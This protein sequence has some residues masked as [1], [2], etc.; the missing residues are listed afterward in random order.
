MVQIHDRPRR[1]SSAVPSRRS[2]ERNVLKPES[3]NGFDPFDA[4]NTESVNSLMD[5]KKDVGDWPTGGDSDHQTFDPFGV[6]ATEMLEKTIQK[7]SERGA[8]KIRRAPGRSNSVGTLSLSMADFVGVEKEKEK[9]KQKADD[10]MEFEAIDWNTTAEAAP[11]KSSKGRSRRHSM[12]SR[13]GKG[14]KSDTDNESVENP[15]EKSS[16]S[17]EKP[18]SSSSSSSKDKDKYKDASE[19]DKKK[20]KKVRSAK[21]RR[22]SLDSALSNT[23]SADDTEEDGFGPVKTYGFEQP[24][25]IAPSDR[26]K[27][28][29]RSKSGSSEMSIHSWKSNEDGTTAT[30]T[31][32]TPKRVIHRR[33][34]ENPMLIKD[35][36]DGFSLKAMVA[37]FAYETE[38]TATP[39]STS[40]ADSEDD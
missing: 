15:F 37:D 29:T 14:N 28:M 4:S 39:N 5:K 3:N 20:K 34:S 35:Q 38:T 9:E 23:D 40:T 22:Q 12:D 19:D 1:R 26:R 6:G 7:K 11:K 27:G 17:H 32:K 21:T 13:P 33:R 10:D 36:G 31:A 25:A 16:H 18:S 24:A 8:P 2:S 30:S